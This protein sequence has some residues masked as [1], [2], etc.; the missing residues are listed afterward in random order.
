MLTESSEVSPGELFLLSAGIGDADNL[1]LK[2]LNTLKRADLVLAM[3]FLQQQLAA[4][5][6][7]GIPVLDPGHGLFS[8]LA[9]RG[10][11]PIDIARK[12][13]EIRERIRMAISQGRCVVVV[14]FG[15][16]T[17]FGPQAGYLAEFRDL[18]P[19][20]LPGISSFNA[21][22]ALLGQPLLHDASQRLLMTTAQGLKNYTG[23]LPDIL[24]LF[25]MQLDAPTL[26]QQLLQRYPPDTAVA[27]VFHAG[28][29]HAQRSTHLR[30]DELATTAGALNIP[31]E[32]LIYVG[33]LLP[34]ATTVPRQE[35]GRLLP[36]SP[37]LQSTRTR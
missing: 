30:L 28:F 24:V 5:L 23:S 20:I 15:D 13:D 16:P 37:E 14:E 17:L 7:E 26:S 35:T 33:Q 25:T 36:E 22:N 27:L 4:Y 19:T 34:P 3:P 1:T 11:N 18:N 29:S 9:R 8:P 12:E 21:A 2:A 31:R 10:G 6:P 32:C